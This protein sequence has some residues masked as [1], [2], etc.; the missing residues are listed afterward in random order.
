MPSISVLAQTLRHKQFRYVGVDGP[1]GVGKS[2]LAKTLARQCGYQLVQL[3]HFVQPGLGYFIQAIDY[4]RLAKVIARTKPPMIV[5]GICLLAVLEKLAL[6]L[7]YLVYVPHQPSGKGYQ[8]TLL[9]QELKHY[10]QVYQPESHASATLVTEELPMTS[11]YDVD[12]AYIKSK[13]LVSV[14]LAIG[15]VLQTLVGALLLNSGLNAQSGATLKIMG[16]EMSAT[17][18]GGIILS[19]SVL[20]AYF[21]YL[22]RPKF[23]TRSETRHTTGADGS[24]EIYE[25]KSSTQMLVDPAAPPTVKG[26]AD[27]RG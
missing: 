6:P 9:V 18:M 23:S 1:I 22:A 8:S 21:A 3:D 20:W 19:T 2:W 10:H 4:Q 24:S 7:N 26:E 15:G 12:I 25:F 14:V 17:G 11:S 27:N 13:T 16:A 5:E